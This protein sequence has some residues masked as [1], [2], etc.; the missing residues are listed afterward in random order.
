MTAGGS[1]AY[2]LA[3]ALLKLDRDAKKCTRCV[4][5]QMAY[6]DTRHRKDYERILELA[7]QIIEAEQHG[8]N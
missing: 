8:P 6:D 1:K 5:P 3:R 4:D 2:R 7:R